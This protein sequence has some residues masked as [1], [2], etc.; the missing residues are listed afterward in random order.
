MLISQKNMKRV[1]RSAIAALPAIPYIMKSRGRTSVTTYLLGG[2]GFAVA[3]GL[4]ALMMLSPRTRSRALSAAK[5]T[6][7]K[8]NDKIG[9]LH[10]PGRQVRGDELPISNGLAG[11]EYS[12]TTSGL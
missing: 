6:Y 9:H 10:P 11:H 2:L 1:L 3:G 8:V 5:T 4:V 7:G 12:T